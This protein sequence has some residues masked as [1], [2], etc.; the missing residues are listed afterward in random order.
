MK[1]PLRFSRRELE[2]V[3][4]CVHRL[5]DQ[6]RDRPLGKFSS[7]EAAAGVSP[8][9]L[10]AI[11]VQDAL[12]DSEKARVRLVFPY[13]MLLVVEAF[14]SNA[15]LSDSALGTSAATITHSLARAALGS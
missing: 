6:S 10:I 7:P 3:R 1:V 11:P 4:A 13:S 8:F 9:G 2:V 15:Y 14:V 12:C 5:N